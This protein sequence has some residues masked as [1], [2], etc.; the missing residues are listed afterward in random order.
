M[1]NYLCGG[2]T[3]RSWKHYWLW[4]IIVAPL[5]L[6]IDSSFFFNLCNNLLLVTDQSVW[7][8]RQF[9]NQ[10]SWWERLHALQ[11][12][13]WGKCWCRSA[14]SLCYVLVW[15]RIIRSRSLERLNSFKFT[16]RK[17]F[18]HIV[19]T[20]FTQTNMSI[21]FQGIFISRV[22]TGGA[23]EKA[24]VHVGDRLLEVCNLCSY[25][26]TVKD[27]TQHVVAWK[28][29]ILYFILAVRISS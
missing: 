29:I 21:S 10:H 19:I 5:K 18:E 8:K 2:C 16:N 28:E 7:P 15:L 6:H 1:S 9:G 13:W 23:S 26:L 20:T 4:Q 17:S 22:N 12:P 14:L 25:S 27:T 24:G 11:R 3:R